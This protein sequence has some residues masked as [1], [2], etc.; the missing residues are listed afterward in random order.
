MTESVRNMWTLSLNSCASVHESM[1]EL[2]GLIVKSSEQHIDVTEA[3]RRRDVEDYDKFRSWLEKRNPFLYTD[4]NLHSLSTGLTSMSGKDTVNCDESEKLGTAIHKRLNGNT[5]ATASIKRKD[6]FRSLESL[7]NTIKICDSS[8]SINPTVL[9]TR[10]TAVAQREED[11]G[12]YFAYEMSPSPPSLFKD[13]LTRKPDK[14]SLRKALM[15]MDDAIG[16]ED[17]LK[18]G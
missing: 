11:V 2:T 14:S 8:E 6:Q 10:L 15:K 3:R 16:K 17:I 7:S 1:M 18:V 13:G 9:F 5:L 12:K 4:S